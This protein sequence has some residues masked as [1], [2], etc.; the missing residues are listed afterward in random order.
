MGGRTAIRFPK[1]LSPAPNHKK[2][3]I[4][5]D[6]RKKETPDSMV[7]QTVETAPTVVVTSAFSPQRAT[8]AG[9][10]GALHMHVLVWYPTE[11]GHEAT[12]T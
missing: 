9:R 2:T 7:S 8:Q 4:F 6:H 12:Y 3:W 5:T 10:Q 11:G 1:V